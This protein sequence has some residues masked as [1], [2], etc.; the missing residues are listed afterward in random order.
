MIESK[1][2]LKKGNKIEKRICFFCKDNNYDL[3]M[4]SLA[5]LILACSKDETSMAENERITKQ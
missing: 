5:L 4:I 2:N 3:L 1:I